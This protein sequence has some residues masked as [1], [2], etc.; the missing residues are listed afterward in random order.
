METDLEREGLQH[1]A[2]IEEELEEIKR[3]TPSPRR[4]F[5]NGVLQGGG[6]FLGGIVAIIAIGGVIWLFGFTGFAPETT[7]YLQG[8]IDKLQR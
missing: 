4:A 7:A 6:A 1:L 3:R 5:W 8:V 2:N